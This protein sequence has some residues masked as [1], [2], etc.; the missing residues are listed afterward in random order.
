MLMNE[1]MME[2]IMQKMYDKQVVDI[3]V[4]MLSEDAKMP[5]YKTPGSAGFDIYTVGGDVEIPPNTFGVMIPTGLAFEIPEGYEIQIR[6][7]SGIALKTT[8]RLS[9]GIGTIDA[10]YK[11]EVKI[12]IDNI[13]DT[14]HT[15][16]HGTRLAQGVISELVPNRMTVIDEL[17]DSERG[18]GGF[19]STGLK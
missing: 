6:A 3:G 2:L 5:E 8:L 18:E 11:G 13:G 17:T 16:E 9:N 7:R 14:P 19:N 4:K 1:L 10:D 15:I 12:L